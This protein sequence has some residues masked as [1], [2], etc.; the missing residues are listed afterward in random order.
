M[1]AGLVESNP[2]E[3]MTSVPTQGSSRPSTRLPYSP[4]Q[5]RLLLE[6]SSKLE[7]AKKWVVWICA[8][9]GCRVEEVCGARAQDVKQEQGV[10]CLDLEPTKDRRLKTRGSA[11]KIPLHPEVLKAGFLDYVR[12]LPADGML[13]PDLPRQKA[14]GKYSVMFGRW[15]AKWS[16][17]LGQGLDDPRVVLHSLRGSF[18]RACRDAGI[19]EELHDQLT[20]HV[21]ASVGRRYGMGASLKVLAEAVAKVSYEEE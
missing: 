20:G 10:W 4:A 18:K 2:F 8:Y 16:G 1:Q 9:S 13:W 5:V 14:K 12:S 6:E 7:G 21:T 11:R 19:Q 17:G 15:F 3:G